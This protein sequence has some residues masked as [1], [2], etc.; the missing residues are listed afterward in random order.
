LQS[1]LHPT[2]LWPSSSMFARR[3][4]STRGELPLLLPFLLRIVLG[5]RYVLSCPSDQKSI[6]S[7]SLRNCE[8]EFATSDLPSDSAREQTCWVECLL[9]ATVRR[10]RLLHHGYALDELMK[11]FMSLMAR[12]LA[13]AASG[14]GSWDFVNCRVRAVLKD[15]GF[16]KVVRKKGETLAAG[17]KARPR[18]ISRH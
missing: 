10:C 5:A 4:L 11:L 7:A 12:P 1:S 9:G 8:F 17:A 14:H 6:T 18:F 13:S 15:A 2:V 3:L 16:A